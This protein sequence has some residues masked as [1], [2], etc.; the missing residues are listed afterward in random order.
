MGKETKREWDW[1]NMTKNETQ[2]IEN[3]HEKLSVM[4]FLCKN[5]G[6]KF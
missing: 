1:V 2:N 3:V 4:D 5:R 6:V